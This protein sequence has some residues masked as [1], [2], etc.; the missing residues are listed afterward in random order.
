MVW[1]ES[2]DHYGFERESS[3]HLR[4]SY[5]D[6][7]PAINVNFIVNGYLSDRYQNDR[8][9]IF[10]QYIKSHVGLNRM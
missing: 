10:A 6:I 4:L 3:S 9:Y 8:E 1:Y 2:E 5:C 7:K